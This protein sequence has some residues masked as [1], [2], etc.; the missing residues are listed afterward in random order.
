MKTKILIQN[1]YMLAFL[2]EENNYEVIQAFTGEDGITSAIKNQPDIILLDIQLPEMDGYTVARKLR[3]CEDLKNTP[4]IAVTS[5]AMLGDKERVLA[6]GAT[7]YIEK[8]VDPENFIAKM[9]E[10][11]NTAK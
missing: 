6:A 3:G 11:I 4:I 10:I 2:L 5:Y 7:G 8:P 1:M 9:K